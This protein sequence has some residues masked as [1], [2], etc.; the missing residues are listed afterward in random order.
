[1]KTV[2]RNGKG[3][4]AQC[5]RLS[6]LV[7]SSGGGQGYCLWVANFVVTKGPGTSN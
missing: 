4:V 2:C 5:Q 3:V 6:S 1:M 7:L